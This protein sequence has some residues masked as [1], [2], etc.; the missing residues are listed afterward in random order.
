MK[1]YMLISAVA[2]LSLLAASCRQT[3]DPATGDG[4]SIGALVITS[5]ENI[6]VPGDIVF[7]IS[8]SD[9][10][11]LSTL[12]VSATL[13]NGT[14]VASASIRTSGKSV[15]LKDQRL[16]VPFGPG[17]KAGAALG[18]TFEAINVE[19]ASAK[20]TKTLS[21]V[22]PTLPETLY[23]TIGE[24]V[25]PMS[26]ESDVLYT[27][28]SGSY[29]SITSALISTAESLSE[30]DIIWGAS[31]RQNVAAVGTL[32]SDK[33]SLSY[34]SILVESWSFNVETF[35][36]T[37]N[38]E[39]L[40]ISVNGVSLLPD[41][42]LLYASVNFTNGAEVTVSGIADIGKAYNRDF[43]SYADGKLTFLRESGVY[44]LWYSP[45]YNYLYVAQ[46]D[47]EAPGCLWV[48]GHGFSSAPEWHEDFFFGGWDDSDITRVGYAVKVGADLYQATLYLSNLHEWGTFEF[49]VYSNRPDWT[50]DKGFAGTSLSGDTKGVALSGAGD[51]MPGLTS[52]TGFQPGYY[53]ITFNN[54]SGEI[55]LER[56]TE[57]VDYGSSGLSINGVELDVD[58]AFDYAT[59]DFTQGAEVV[60]EGFK[61]IAGAYNRDFFAQRDGKYYFT[62]P[63]G[64]YKVQY[65]D[66]Y[67]YIWVSNG[68]MTFPDCIY[69]LGDGKFSAP[70]RPVQTWDGYE[71]NA[72][73]FAVAPK[74][75]ENTY[76]AT[77]SLYPANE[78][79]RVLLEFYSDLS[80]NQDGV[81]P[82]GTVTG[83]AAAGFEVDV[84]TGYIMGID[85]EEHPFEPGYY[86][87]LITVVDGGTAVEISKIGE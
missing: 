62:A 66:E 83:P 58:P 39:T 81:L 40:A 52:D 84:E 36:V 68:D 9:D 55:H 47:N 77:M 14:V 2:A 3:E 28:E 42:G 21:I 86:Q 44:D 16:S 78:G 8:V 17:M 43:F 73:Y 69:I 19:G 45:K 75:D 65:Y 67:N 50:K 32:S 31:D 60:F 41:N 5:G 30:S 54:A 18:V 23:M 26:K 63:T 13:D 24:T 76:K 34:P 72:P 10:V 82:N 20:Q 25:Y 1:K 38:G 6:A 70:L 56:L 46:W 79:N 71:R 35:E 29:E 80:W 22:R 57:W 51:D 11:N 15:E 64:T 33:I 7:D 12:E 85:T 48:M 37:A 61:D 59:I 87:L 74:V 27:T 49:E 4:P 53:V